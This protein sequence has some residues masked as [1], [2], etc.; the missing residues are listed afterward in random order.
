MHKRINFVLFLSTVILAGCGKD[1]QP[2]PEGT[3]AVEVEESMDA[4]QYTYMRVSEGDNEYWI[5]VPKMKVE[6]GE[7]LYYSKSM[8]MNN[9]ESK[10]LNR[11]FD[12]VLFVDDISKIRPTAS[13][14]KTPMMHPKVETM[15]NKDIKVDPLKDGKTIGQIY[16]EKDKIAGSKVRV[17]G[18][19]IKYNPEI[20]SRNWIHLQDG[21]S[22]G[23]NF[24]LMVTSTDPAEVGEVVIAEG[25][26]ALNKDFGAGYVYPVMIENAKIIKEEKKAL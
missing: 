4:S 15:Q 5:A 1:E 25:M 12:K 23:E 20:M 6:E 26:V 8:V 19:V 16:S 10:T 17:R 2:L 18:K 11:T 24:D 13:M 21:T 3:H 22:F 14:P 7:M 9:F